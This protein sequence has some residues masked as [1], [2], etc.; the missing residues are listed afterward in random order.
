MALLSKQLEAS[1]SHKSEYMRR[2]NEAINE[3]KQLADDYM[4]RISVIQSG[5]SSLEERCSSIRK[6]LESAKEETSEW[7]RKH[8]L[9]M[10]K[11]KSVEDLN[12]SEITVL[13]SRSSAAE[14]R[15][16]AA[17]EQM[18][19]AQEEAAEWKRKYDMTEEE[20]KEKSS[21]IEQA[22][23]RITTLNLELKAAESRI[24][25]YDAEVVSLKL[26]IRTLVERLEAAMANAQSFE[27][28]AR[29]LE[30][31][32]IHIEERYRSEFERFAEVQERCTLAE[33]E[34]KKAVE[35]AD[36][37]RSD[38][39]TAQKEKSEFQKLAM[40]RLA[41]IERAHRMIEN[42]ERERGDLA[43]ELEKVRVS[44]IDA[45][46][47]V[48]QLEGRVDEREREIEKLLKSNN[49]DRAS[50]VRALQGLLEDERKAHSVANKR[51]EELSLQLEE[52]RAKLDTLQQ[53]LTSVRLNESALG[54]KLKAASSHHGKRVRNEGFETGGNKRPRGM[55]S[56]MNRGDGDDDDD[57]DEDDSQ[58]Q[59]T[60][61]EDYRK[62]TIQKLKRELTKH[63]FGEELVELHRSKHPKH[64]NKK[65][66][67][68]L[69][70]KLVL[71]KS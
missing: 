38:A 48:E 63:E 42:L 15:M 8:D 20:I 62:F 54:G 28:E 18:R 37:A 19:S 17:H 50:N 64:P 43:N 27:K 70:E 46:S 41:Q 26:E 68:A 69:Y 49:E 47:R 56:S 21:K 32:K 55:S 16:A 59:Q 61:E 12:S 29:M 67:V 9:V 66:M 11:Q 7:K 5:H 30:Q 35:V 22:E 65:E 52:A 53:E 31:E 25:S 33:R 13:K 36:K 57:V 24:K 3:K 51:A 34:S 39:V 71:Q 40:E 60:D 1:E 2:Y 14:A 58:S 23:Q 45:L 6:A 44:E 10:S 4:K